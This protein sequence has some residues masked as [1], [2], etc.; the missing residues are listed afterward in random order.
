MGAGP[1]D[2]PSFFVF[3]AGRSGTTLLAF[4][5]SG[6]PGTLCLNDTLAYIRLGEA[7]V[8]DGPLAK[9]RLVA[10]GGRL[11]TARALRGGGVRAAY[12]DLLTRSLRRRLGA[13]VP[14]PAH[15]RARF[16]ASLSRQYQHEN[17]WYD[18][19]TRY[20]EPLN[21]AWARLGGMPGA[22]TRQ[23]VAP[24]FQEIAEIV[25]PGAD[26][27]NAGEKTPLHTLVAPWLLGLYP[28]ARGVL[29]VRDPITN[30]ASILKRHR[31]MARAIQMYGRFVPAILWLADHPRVHVTS[32]RTLLNR[33]RPTM[34]AV[35][36]FLKLPDFDATVPVRPFGK[37]K[38]TGTE[39]DPGREPAAESVLTASTR[40][41]LRR[42][43]GDIYQLI[44]RIEADLW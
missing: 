15:V 12:F 5:L 32:Y 41:L 29:L 1:W 7:A 6:Q 23:L 34:E 36:E 17:E 40:D 18:F 14:V 20:A 30:V 4:L 24:I 38:Y 9:I 13:G 26:L 21:R 39:V 19:Q 35:A 3:G 2:S 37:A 11:S 43:H 22:D 33:P 28:E 44:A 8:G 31:P 42:R 16:A 10:E 27:S 25:R